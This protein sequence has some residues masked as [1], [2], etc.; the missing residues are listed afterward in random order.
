MEAL[1][2][3]GFHSG[4]RR[5]VED[6]GADAVDAARG[7]VDGDPAADQHDRAVGRQARRRRLAGRSTAPELA[8]EELAIGAALRGRGAHDQVIE[9]RGSG[10]GRPDRVNVVEI[11]D[12]RSHLTETGGS[13]GRL[14]V[15]EHRV[16]CRLEAVR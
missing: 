11:A 15:R 5:R 16:N 6:P 12:E 7:Q 3:A 14:Q 4:P 13:V 9:T 1:P 10:D 2:F 8:V